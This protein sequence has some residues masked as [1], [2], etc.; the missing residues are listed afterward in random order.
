M[1]GGFQINGWSTRWLLSV[2]AAHLARRTERSRIRGVGLYLA[3]HGHLSC[4][5]E[6]VNHALFA[7]TDPHQVAVTYA[8]FRDL[9]ARVITDEGA[10]ER[11]TAGRNPSTGTDQP[12]VPALT[13]PVTRPSPAARTSVSRPDS[14]IATSGKVSAGTRTLPRPAETSRLEPG[15]C[16]DQRKRA[17]V[18][19][20]NT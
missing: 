12:K 5:I 14:T 7:T 4:W 6:T 18:N 11:E 19:E 1:S 8:E 15:H 16:R 13:G 9:A 3:R 17:G 10:A 2:S 20:V